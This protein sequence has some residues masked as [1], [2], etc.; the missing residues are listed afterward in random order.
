[1]FILGGS[2]IEDNFSRRCTLFSK[3]TK[4]LEKPPMIDRRAFFPSIFC[5]SDSCLYVFGGHDGAADLAA[6]ERYSVQENV[7]RSIQPMRARRNGA[8]VIAFDRVLFVFGGN[9]AQA[10]SLDS[11]ERYA[12]EFDKWSMPRV[13]LKEPVHDTIAFNLG[14]ARV[15]IFGGT[16]KDKPNTRFDVYDLTSECLGAEETQMDVGKIYLPPVYDPVQGVLH[17]FLG[18]GDHELQHQQIKIQSLMC[19]CRSVAFTDKATSSDDVSAEVEDMR[20]RAAVTTSESM[21]MAVFSAQKP[22]VGAQSRL[23]ALA[24]SS[25]QLLH[26]QPK[27][28]V[29]KERNAADWS[30]TEVA[31]DG[32]LNLG[33]RMQ[34][35]RLEEQRG[36]E[37]SDAA[38]AAAGQRP[39]FQPLDQFEL[40]K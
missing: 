35:R 31:Q 1:M 9:N 5:I 28:G 22:P 21:S 39:R 12:V 25:S 4:Y 32:G 20:R 7:W 18:Y 33:A 17:A 6:C 8:S 37:L 36:Q 11:I 34:S 14:G 3:Y 16:A 24:P 38:D 40:S 10:G 2:D 27:Q 30:G 19:T 29:G 13:R 23:P 26:S 15:L